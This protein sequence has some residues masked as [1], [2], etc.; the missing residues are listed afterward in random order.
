MNGFPQYNI[1]KLTFILQ[2]MALNHWH[3]SSQE[4]LVTAY[5]CINTKSTSF[6]TSRIGVKD[7]E[8]NSRD[9]LKPSGEE[10]GDMATQG[11]LATLPKESPD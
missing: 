11:Y 3:S 2:L 8:N 5:I 6:K 10:V 4:R 9:S 1:L 7:L